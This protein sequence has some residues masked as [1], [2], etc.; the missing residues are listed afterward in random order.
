[1]M[2]ESEFLAAYDRFADALFRHCFFRVY[3][4]E[5]ARDLVQE[6][7]V[8]TWEYVAKD[9]DIENIRAFLYRVANNLIIDE[10]R[11]KRALSLDEL[12]EKGFDPAGHDSSEDIQTELDTQAVVKALDGLK[13]E[14]KELVIMRY[15]DGFGPKEI[16]DIIGLSENVISVRLNRAVKELRGLIKP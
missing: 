14:S 6:T 11:R 8:R 9:K 12:L 10:S 1:M 15:I 5:R 13:D 16:A 2:T 3:D 7:F 4:R